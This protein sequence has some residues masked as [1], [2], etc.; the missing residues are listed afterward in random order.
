MP[1]K[2]QKTKNNLANIILCLKVVLLLKQVKRCVF[3]VAV[4]PNFPESE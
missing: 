4:A 3:M 1:S 2:K